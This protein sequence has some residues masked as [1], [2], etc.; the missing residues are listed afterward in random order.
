MKKELAVVLAVFCVI[1]F[2]MAPTAAS[3]EDSVKKTDDIIISPLVIPIGEPKS[4]ITG[5]I[6][7]GQ[8]K[9]YNYDVPAWS[10][11]MYIRLSWSSTSNNL[12]LKFTSP[13]GVT[14]G[15]YDDYYESSIP[16]AIIPIEINSGTVLPSGLWEFQIKGKTVSGSEPFT[17]IVNTA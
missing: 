4:S 7:Q 2:C 12:Q 10:T 16:N 11:Y 17:L 13:T 9:N 5:S 8:V 15:N 14:Y 1:A 3:A 6:V